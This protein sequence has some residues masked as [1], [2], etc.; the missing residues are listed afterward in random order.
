MKNV[1]ENP[2]LKSILKLEI[3]I[4]F[5]GIKRI[6]RHAAEFWQIFFEGCAVHFSDAHSHGACVSEIHFE[7]GDPRWKSR[8]AAGIAAVLKLLNV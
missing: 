2:N 7:I 3:F 4:F 1:M 5:S 8:H 6:L